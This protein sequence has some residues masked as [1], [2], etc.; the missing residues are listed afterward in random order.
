MRYLSC[1]IATRCDVFR[2]VS[3]LNSARDKQVV[4]SK[5][6][7][8]VGYLAFIIQLN[9]IF[10]HS[11]ISPGFGRCTRMTLSQLSRY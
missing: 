3:P 8:V 7:L 11:G 2:F 6:E 5:T 1:Q 4:T 9:Y 10:H